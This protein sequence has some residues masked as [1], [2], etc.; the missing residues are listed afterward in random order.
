MFNLKKKLFS[1]A[2]LV[3]LSLVL[4]ASVLHTHYVEAN[5]AI[6]TTDYT[7][8]QVNTY[9]SSASGLSGSS[10]IRALNT[11]IKGHTSVSYNNA[12]SAMSITDRNWTL[13][14][15]VND[16]D[17]YMNLLYGDQYNDTNGFKWSQDSNGSIW[18]KEH[19]WAKSHGNFGET[20]PA[21]S[22]LHHLIAS[23]SSINTLHANYDI[24]NNNK[25]TSGQDERGNI[26]GYTGTSTTLGSG[27]VFEPLDDVKGNV[28]RALLYMGTRYLDY[29]NTGDP[30]LLL[31]QSITSASTAS[32][33]NPG[34]MGVLSD[35]L[36]WN[37]LDPVDDYE[38]HRNNLIFHNYQGNRN[39]YIDHPEWA[40][41]AY[42]SAYS[43]PGASVA[44]GSS[45]VGG[46]QTTPALSSITLNTSGVQT[47][48]SLNDSFNT[49]GL[50]VI[51]HMSDGSSKS[52]STFTTSPTSGTTL[53]SSGTQSVTVSYTENSVTKTASY[54][55]TITGVT[56]TLSYIVATPSESET[57]FPKGSS[58]TYNALTVMGYY[59]DSS[60]ALISSGYTVTPPSMSTAGTKSVS[61]S[62]EGKSTTYYIQVGE[63]VS[64]DITPSISKVAYGS[65]YDDNDLYG[66]AHFENVN[67]EFSLD[68]L[69]ADVS[70]STLDTS[71]LGPHELNVSYT[72]NGMSASTTIDVFVTN[73]NATIS[74]GSSEPV[75]QS[76]V[77]TAD[78]YLSSWEHTNTSTYSDPAV[79]FDATGDAIKKSNVFVPTS[80]FSSIS[81]IL[82]GG[83]KSNG[84]FNEEGVIKIDL[85]N[86][87]NSVMNESKTITS[88]DIENYTY[89]FTI[90]SPSSTIDGI[91]I[92]FTKVLS[93]FALRNIT[94]TANYLAIGDG[95]ADQ[96]I[97]Y[98]NYFL[99][100]TD[101]YCVP[102]EGNLAPWNELLNEYGFMEDGSI[103]YFINDNE[104]S[105]IALAK[106]RYHYL[107]N[108]YDS[109]KEDNFMTSSSGVPLFPLASQIDYGNSDDIDSLSSIL[110]IT[111]FSITALAGYYFLVKKK[112]R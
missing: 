59:S 66:Y 58:F 35:L 49:L 82:N 36:A 41:I 31:V 48:F 110:L 38:I 96:A 73:E 25:A 88:I 68:L 11:K 61:V 103:D 1:L 55:I 5:A 15:N 93:N 32:S 44:A 69:A 100:I 81:I 6:I 4:G 60:S 22:D 111:I 56:K 90:A 92:S 29:V 77:V 75:T 99:D 33:G 112:H 40:R 46:G 95:Y 63:L 16:T 109:L 64:I 102:L 8:A 89:D 83:M 53:S 62:Y 86:G 50:S 10:L 34:R 37:E 9:F 65:T 51:A 43:G 27:I 108:K 17:P 70:V 78:N 21:G 76:F 20:A 24:G 104:N 84:Q 28:A 107:I 30:N 106:E 3:T 23:D 52:V 14:P 7:D 12:K 57:N 45:S 87:A 67:S 54:S 98:A 13:S 101:E 74:S 97:A 39:P 42:D 79:R 105:S 72:I 26:A 2:L 71:V 47:T 18:N 91:K 94:V 19:T 80:G 85:L